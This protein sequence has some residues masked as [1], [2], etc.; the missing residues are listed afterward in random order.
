MRTEIELEGDEERVRMK[1][2]F[3]V[4]DGIDARGTVT[5]DIERI[6]SLEPQEDGDGRLTAGGD[7][8]Q[9]FAD[10]ALD[11]D[12]QMAVARKELG[13]EDPKEER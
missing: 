3:Q 4:G 9:L 8:M 13:L 2:E 12:R 5:T 7:H 11:V 10:W 1:G 6:C